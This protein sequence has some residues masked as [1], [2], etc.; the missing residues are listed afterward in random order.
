MK[1]WIVWLLV[2]L[3]LTIS[4]IYLLIPSKIVLSSITP[5]QATITAEF[6]FLSNPDKWERWWRDS[7]GK[8]HVKG[9]PFTYNATSFRLTQ[10]SINVAGI[11]LEQSGSKIQSIIHLVSFSIDSTVAVWRCEMPESRNPFTMMVNYK[12][13]LEIKKNMTGIMKNFSSFIS[14]PENVYGINIYRTGTRDA[15]LLS[16]RFTS[17]IYPTTSE[18]Y[19]YFD[20]LNK[21][22]EKQHGLAT[23]FPMVNVVKLDNDSFET[24]VAIPTNHQLGN[25]GKISFR[26]MVPGNFMMAEV[27]GGTYTANEAQK[28]LELFISDYNRFKIANS[29]QSLVTN[30][31]HEPDT[32]KWVTKIYIPVVK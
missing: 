8:N 25:D 20:V 15:T 2:I 13:A 7:N 31:L 6:R 1:K 22:I 23:G 29:F 28:E 10:H 9:D 21:N 11:E 27:K 4:C 3:I 5:A 32:S 12:N 18:L 26:R 19:G 30:R 14:K 16:A 24:Q 17:V